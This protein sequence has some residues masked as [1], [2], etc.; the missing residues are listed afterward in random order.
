[1]RGGERESELQVG[2]TVYYDT[3]HHTHNV[4]LIHLLGL[5]CE[6]IA[7]PDIDGKVLVRFDARDQRNEWLIH[8]RHLE[9]SSS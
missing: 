7:E 2:E 5:P 3:A 1:M 9:R 4:D 8:P 6:V